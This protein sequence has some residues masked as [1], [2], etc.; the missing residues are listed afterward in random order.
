MPTYSK[1]T[2]SSLVTALG[3]YLQ[4]LEN[5]GTIAFWSRQQAGS[6]TFQRNGKWSKVRQGRE[7]ISDL[8]AIALNGDMLWIEAKTDIGKQRPEQVEFQKIVEDCGHHYLLV[9]SCDDLE[10]EFKRIGIL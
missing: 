5:L 10:K 7:G 1:R 9:R 8:W 2:E 6:L 3:K 4:V